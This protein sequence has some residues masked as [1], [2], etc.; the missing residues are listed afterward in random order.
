MRQAC[1]RKEGARRRQMKPKSEGEIRQAGETDSGGGNEV[2]RRPKGGAEE[3]G[4]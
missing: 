4:R 1:D 2:D 3:A